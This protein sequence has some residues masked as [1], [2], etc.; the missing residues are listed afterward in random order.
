MAEIYLRHTLHGTKIATMELEAEADEQNGW[1]RFDPNN[2]DDN[3]DILPEPVVAVN[4][5]AEAP[6]R[7]TRTRAVSDE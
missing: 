4:I 5:L 7:R 6:R 1:E 3:D 2:P